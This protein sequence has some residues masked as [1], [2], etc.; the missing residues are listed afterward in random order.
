[1]KTKELLERWASSIELF[2]DECLFAKSDKSPSHQQRAVLQDIDAGV[3]DISIADFAKW[4]HD[5]NSKE[6]K[7]D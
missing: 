2:V 5:E 7:D 4:L 1:M 6:G 3:K